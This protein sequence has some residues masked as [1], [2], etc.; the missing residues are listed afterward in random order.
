MIERVLVVDDEPLARERVL[1][2]LHRV[3]PR[4]QVYEA[5]DGD[6]AIAQIQ[7]LAPD[8]VLLDIEMPA[9]NGLDVI[10]AIG[11][12]HMP[13]TIFITAYDGH[14]VAAFE[15]AAIDYL[16][17]PFDDLRFET[18]WRRLEQRRAA[19]A[20]AGEARRLQELLAAL[21]GSAGGTT[22]NDRK[23]FVIREGGR[24]VVVPLGEIEWIE[25][26]GNHV[27]LHS[28]KASFRLRD[29]LSAVAARLDP[30]RFVRIHRR[31]L[32]DMTAMRELH[33]WSGGDQLIVLQGGAKLPVSRNYRSELA[34][35]LE[36]R[37]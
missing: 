35:R 19:G 17:K 21:V 6:S 24:T 29:T 23:R 20:L 16:L 13:P 30:A 15:L 5:A 37:S 9:C 3:A 28:A 27:V 33:P 34:R 36:G 12:E 2:L 14:A 10:A 32:V 31:F 8:A 1:R 18:A 11:C 25:S 7:S 22:D 4:T 26:S